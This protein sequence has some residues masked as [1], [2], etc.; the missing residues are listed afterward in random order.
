MHVNSVVIVCC[1]ASVSTV[2]TTSNSRTDSKPSTTTT[3]TSSMTYVHWLGTSPILA[4]VKN[5]NTVDHHQKTNSFE[6]NYSTM[7]HSDVNTSTHWSNS[8]SN[9]LPHSAKLDNST[10]GKHKVTVDSRYGSHFGH[11]QQS[12]SNIGQD[13]CLEKQKHTSVKKSR[14]GSVSD[15][16]V[17]QKSGS[18]D[19][20]HAKHENSTTEHISRRNSHRS[21]SSS[22][23][24]EHSYSKSGSSRDA[25][26]RTS[27]SD[28]GD[29]SLDNSGAHKRERHNSSSGRHQ[30]RRERHGS[31]SARQSDDRRDGSSTGRDNSSSDRQG[32]RWDG[33]RWDRQQP[34]EVVK[35]L[36]SQQQ[37]E[38]GDKG[39]ILLL[40]TV[41][42]LVYPSHLLLCFSCHKQQKIG[43]TKVWRIYQ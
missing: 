32:V 23:Q 16:S 2:T 22:D 9:K 41:N 6:H 18:R 4:N 15:T 3:T 17:S 38:L 36:T 25:G 26:R 10:V 31:S 24:Q 12:K 14:V 42:D 1:T 21:G 33:S 28:Y 20:Y 30:S 29:D 19:S 11:Q 7:K 37:Y 13:V 40:V 8:F 27:S 43:R 34:S 39:M 5:T 35:H